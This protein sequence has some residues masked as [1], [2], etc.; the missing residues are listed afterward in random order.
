[1]RERAQA[2]LDAAQGAATPR[3][4]RD[5]DVSRARACRSCASEA[6]SA[7]ACSPA[8]RS[9]IPA[10]IEPIVAELA[11]TADRARARA[12]QWRISAWKN[13][14]VAPAAGAAHGARTTTSLPPRAPMR[15]RRRAA[16]VSGGGLRRPDRAAGGAARARR[17]RARSAGRRAARMCWSTSTRTRTRRSTGCCARSSATRTPF[18]AVGDD[19]QAIYGWRGATL[20]NLGRAAA[21]LSGRS[22]SSSSSRTTGR[23]CAS[24]AAPTR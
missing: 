18:T 3:E 6:R 16:R 14:L 8:S 10:D 20:D 12:A 23:R 2:L 13:A 21:R 24:C 9:S 22:R 4:D 11:A 15:L 7:R 5:L 1:M 19:D 17:R